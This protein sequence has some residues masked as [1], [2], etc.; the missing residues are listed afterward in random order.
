MQEYPVKRGFS[1][2][3]PATMVEQLKE[4]F[5]T[6]PKHKEG[7]YQI[8]YGALKVLDASLGADGKSI[9]IRTESDLKVTDETILD[10][11][12]RFRK[13]LDA[14]TGYNTKERVKKAKTV[15]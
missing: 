13:Y 6:E 3:L 12:R 10:T 11:N 14:V 7:H 15:E 5:G 2:N 9:I 4:C 8:S 1:K